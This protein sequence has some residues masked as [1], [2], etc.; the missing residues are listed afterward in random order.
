[1][2]KEEKW[3][4]VVGYEGLYQVSNLGR[5]KRIGKAP[6]TV[7]G[8]ILSTP[9]NSDGY[10]ICCLHNNGRK[11][12]RVHRIVA[13]AFLGTPPTNKP[14]VNHLDGNKSNNRI[15][16]LE[17]TSRSENLKHVFRCLGREPVR[18][19]GEKSGK[20][21]I[22]EEDVREIRKLAGQ[23]IPYSKIEKLYPIGKAQIRRI[24]ILEKWKHVK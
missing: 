18:I 10:P 6:G 22:T 21:A 4:D 7:P 5:V 14:E 24:V 20:N 2:I 9:L 8:Y 15:E 11:T 1:M 23:K 16:N 12:T 3:K 19:C 17:Y 13:R